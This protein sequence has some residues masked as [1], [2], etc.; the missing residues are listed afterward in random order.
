MRRC[1]GWHLKPQSDSIVSEMGTTPGLAPRGSTEHSL[2][3]AAAERRAA[4]RHTSTV[5]AVVLGIL[6]L[7]VAGALF[8]WHL[9]RPR[10]EV[11]LSQVSRPASIPACQA[12][13]KR[14]LGYNDD[15]THCRQ[16]IGMPWVRVSVHNA[17]H[18]GAADF[19]CTATVLTDYG[20]ATV[21]L[22]RPGGIPGVS[23]GAGH[24]IS[25]VT[26][27]PVPSYAPVQSWR[28][29]CQTIAHPG[30]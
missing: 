5:L 8:A 17:G 26:Y 28:G 24:T 14:N 18:R 4:R 6:V 30:T 15:A 21:S 27:V 13:V 20:Q 2:Q 7:V 29:E 19:S 25:W 12:V 9:T 3:L 16:E 22:S 23:L 11:S 10:L 1:L